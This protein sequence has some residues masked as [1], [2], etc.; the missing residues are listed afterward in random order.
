MR[1]LVYFA[2]GFGAA[3]ALSVYYLPTALLLP[4]AIL[5]LLLGTGLLLSRKKDWRRVTGMI[6]LGIAAGQLW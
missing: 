6:L 2:I 4:L 5:L 3:C 1:K